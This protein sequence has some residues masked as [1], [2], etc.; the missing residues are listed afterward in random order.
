MSCM[1]EWTI[2]IKNL[3]VSYCPDLSGKSYKLIS[4]IPRKFNAFCGCKIL[5]IGPV[6]VELLSKE[7]KYRE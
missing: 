3:H 6:M 2:S 5:L 1:K 7:C 4:L